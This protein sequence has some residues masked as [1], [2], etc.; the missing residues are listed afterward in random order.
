MS[1]RRKREREKGERMRDRKEGM[2]DSSKDGMARR[3]K[4]R[5]GKDGTANVERKT[6]R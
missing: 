5:G 1:N 3:R 2:R 6:Q 4:G